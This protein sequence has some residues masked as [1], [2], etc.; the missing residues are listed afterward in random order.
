MGRI[1]PALFA[2]A[3][4]ALGLFPALATRAQEEKREVKASELIRSV[5]VVIV[6]ESCQDDPNPDGPL[7]TPSVDDCTDDGHSGSGTIIDASGLILTNAHVALDGRYPDP[8]ARPAWTIVGLTSDAREL[9]S[10]AFFA[11][12]IRYDPLLDLALLKPFFTLDGRPIEEG[13]INLPPLG[14]GDPGAVQIDDDLRNLGYPGIG[15]DLI[16]LTS[17][18]VSGFE[19]D[20]NNPDLGTGAWIKTDATLGGGISGGTTVNPFG[21]LIGVPTEIG[22]IEL[23][24]DE[25]NPIPVGQINHIRPVPEAYELLLTR[26]VDA[27]SEAAQPVGPTLPGFDPRS[28][29][30]DPA[31]PA[32]EPPSQP[33]TIPRRSDPPVEP[34][35]N[36]AIVTGDLVSADTDDPIEGGFFLVLRPETTVNDFIEADGDPNLVFTVAESNARGRFQTEGPIERDR[37]YA[38]VVLADGFEPAFEDGLVLATE[39]DPATVDFGV[40]EL[41]SAG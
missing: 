39:N 21:Q 11:R 34:V 28:V 41:A 24:G 31:T 26:G 2:L 25:D 36:G 22:D 18:E 19:A 3:L 32:A 30:G 4:L 12:A 7:G 40:I 6:P 1:R 13:E 33:G 29:P 27:E 17:G 16:T 37:E 8:A 9:P 10:L 20:P 23:R 14:M 15:S 35:E 38:V 5:V